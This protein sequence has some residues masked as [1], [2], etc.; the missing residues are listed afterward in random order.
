[1]IQTLKN[2]LLTVDAS[3]AGAELLS[4]RANRTGQEYLWHGDKAF[5]GRRSPI[6]FPLVGS[7]WEGRFRMDGNE[8]SMSQHGFARDREFLP[9]EGAPDDEAWFVLEA[10]DETLK[11]YPRLFR[12]ETG[13]RLDGERI[14]VTWRVTNNDS[15]PMAF[16]I[17]AHPAFNYPAFSAA[18]AVHGYF[19]FGR[20]GLKS[21]RIEEKG[22]VGDT[23][24]DI[25]LDSAMMLPLTADTFSHDALILA[26]SQVRRVSLLDKNRTPLLS[27]LFNAPLVGLWSP[28]PDAPFVCIEPWW[29]RCDRVG[30][31]GEFADRE[32]T[33][34]LLP[35]HTFEASYMIIIENL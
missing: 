29:G 1:M 34:I 15:R 24:A 20:D 30:F 31:T 9:L 19:L 4:I 22:C 17:G 7:V 21:Q 2:D 11:S 13:Y 14:T 10:D 6:L 25:R 12:L 26:D 16:H 32:Y 5:W 35:G 28:R 8:Y 23:V 27:L 3:S 33:N 18:D